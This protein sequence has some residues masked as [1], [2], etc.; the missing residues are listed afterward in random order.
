MER[1]RAAMAAAALL[2]V[3]AVP[4]G[5]P[6]AEA[7]AAAV[8]TDPVIEVALGAHTFG[9]LTP[10]QAVVARVG[11]GGVGWVQEQ[12]GASYG[13]GSFEVAANGAVWLLDEVND[14]LLRW[15]PGRRTRS[16][17]PCRSPPAPPTSPS[18]RPG[19]S[20]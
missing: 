6:R 18:A 19:R 2:T 13:P 12:E 20:T 7:A 10:A 1:S 16:P 11:P 9:A 3:M 14:R 15:R 5:A 17:P 4:A 8:R